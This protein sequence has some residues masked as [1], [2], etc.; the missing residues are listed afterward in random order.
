MRVLKPT[1]KMT[2]FLQ[3]VT[4]TPARP[5][6]LGHFLGQMIQTITPDPITGHLNSGIFEQMYLQPTPLL[7]KKNRIQITTQF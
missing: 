3:Q 1:A 2:H 6:L 7:K 5:H 4:P